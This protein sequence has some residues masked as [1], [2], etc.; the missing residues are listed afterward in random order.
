MRNIHK[1]FHHRHVLKK[2]RKFKSLPN[3]IL[4]IVLLIFVTPVLAD[5]LGPDRTTT[6]SYVET[7][8]IGVWTKDYDGSCNSKYHQGCIVCTWKRKPGSPC[9]DAKYWYKTGE[10]SKVVKET[11]EHPPAT[12]N[13]SLE[14]CTLQ[15]GWCVTA[16]ELALNADEPMDGYNILAIEGTLNGQTF[17][18][19]QASCSVPLSE[20]DNDLAYWALS[21][22]GDSS[23]MGNAT[24]KVD[25]VSPDVGLDVSG[26][27]GENG[28]YT[29]PVTVTS[30]GSDSTSGLAGTSLSVDSGAWQ[31]TTTLN[32]GIYHIAV[33][34]SDNAGN[35]SDA[36]TIISVD[37]TTPSIDLSVNGTTGNDGWYVSRMEVTAAADNST[38]GVALLEYSMDGGTYQSY[39]SPFS[40]S[41]GSHV[42]QFKATDAAGNFTETP[43]QAYHINSTAPAIS[44]PDS[45]TVDDVATYKA[46]DDGSGLASIRVIIEDED[47]HYAKITNKAVS[48]TKFR[49]EI[50]WDGK[51]ND[52][53]VA[54]PGTYLVWVKA[55]D[56]AGN[57]ATR[58]GKVVVNDSSL[59]LNVSQQPD[60]ASTEMVEMPSP[61]ADLF[62]EGEASPTVTNNAASPALTYGGS[63]S[64]STGTTD[65][66]S[67]LLAT[68]TSSTSSNS[69]STVL[70]GAA[71]AAVVGAATSYALDEKRK[72]E[73][74][75]EK[76]AR[77]AA[78][79]AAQ[80]NAAEEARK[81]ESWLEGYAILNAQ[82]EEARKQ[83]ATDAQISIFKQI[84]E[85]KGLGTA[86][87]AAMNLTEFLHATATQQTRQDRA[88][89]SKL[90]RLEAE[91]DAEW[92][93]SH[94]AAIERVEEEKKKELQDG[95]AA[96][97]N[98]AQAGNTEASNA[99]SNWWEN[100]KSSVAE[101]IIQ[102]F[103]TYIY[104]P[105]LEPAIEKT[106][107]AV[108]KGASWV[109][110]HF[111]QPVVVPVVD[112]EKQLASKEI[113]WADQNIYQPVIKPIVDN[114]VNDIKKDIDYLNEKV[115]QPY[116]ENFYEPVVKPAMDKLADKITEGIE[117]A[118]EKIY[119]PVIQ[120]AVEAI[121]TWT[122]EQIYQ[123][124]IQPV[125]TTIDEKIYQPFIEPVVSDIDK[126][127]YQPYLKPLNDA[128][129]AWW[130]DYGEW[131]HNAIDLV[132][133]IPGIGDIADG[134][135]SLI[136]LA[137]GRYL[138]ATISA[139]S[140]IP[141]V[142]D[143]G[144]A[145]KVGLEVSEEIVEEG[146]EVLI[147]K[148]V[149][150]GGEEL[151]EKF[152]KETVEQ[153]AETT[154]KEAGEELSEKIVKESVEEITE[155][156]V[157]ETGEEL[158]S[159][160]TQQVTKEIAETTS[161]EVSEVVVGATQ[162]ALNYL[163]NVPGFGELSKVGDALINLGKREF[164]DASISLVSIVPIVGEGAANV[165][166]I[167]K[168][169][170]ELWGDAA[171]E[172]LETLTSK[173]AKE[174]AEEM[175]ELAVKEA[176]EEL[177][178]KLVQE[179]MEEVVEKAAQESGEELIEK[180]A[181]E[182]VEEA[183][184]KTIQEG[185]E[186]LAEKAVQETAEETA[187]KTAKE[188]GEELADKTTQEA[189]EEVSEKT[190]RE[191]G[192]EI[193]EKTTDE[194]AEAATK[195]SI[196]EAGEEATEALA[197]KTTKEAADEAAA[198]AAKEAFHFH[199][200]WRFKGSFR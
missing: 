36:S 129:S 17:A 77:Q 64:K 156:T 175:T 118:N 80:L 21:S 143:L 84:G 18:C 27:S 131:V 79:Q 182:T 188:A 103:K 173:F 47:E 23:T 134:I 194:V 139:L 53:T 160:A 152:T 191:S 16:P 142:G 110:E 128:A 123:P 96:Y 132:G 154:V 179:S 12:I 46:Q 147:E 127:I 120:P 176:G 99:Q 140:M 187:E 155:K 196:K 93:A 15:N 56:A 106:K 161:K 125:L 171:K 68:G 91:E 57:S 116:L 72:R 60:A 24:A 133:L 158:A 44:L 73:E 62:E 145:G 97:Y 13:G 28:W 157:K 22:W 4:V 3:L 192:E 67:L 49:G 119:E 124:L 32:E 11:V 117:W 135:N 193:I 108:T 74:E 200:Q 138:E 54:P 51:F 5:Y 122:N 2:F 41:D 10:E 107:E 178:T 95:L 100:G 7:Y 136:Y 94:A 66:A 113:E 43:M 121:S 9:G 40:I 190:A 55:S 180:A 141:L 109:D 92:A 87:G 20:G 185:S 6:K 59:L 34:A 114:A 78:K 52:G 150:E 162:Q 102:P 30:T 86:V 42:F 168:G 167:L 39:T 159:Q 174:S 144:K 184:E 89:E 35:V 166:E 82:I 63:T 151:V 81:A 169:T 58:L 198:K 48:G 146:A 111:V 112:F 38:S 153:V 61:P 177:G 199:Q 88:E 33:S 115:Y 8:D 130:D 149:K 1:F 101:N 45:W 14:N 164:F 25:T 37:M 163:G 98:A 83:G 69:A 26:S 50:D 165:L 90:Q 126:Y 197:E 195:K 29:S 104:Q 172:A 19:E 137:E 181:V 189:F 75:E 65:Q 71:A 70:W 148:A 186:E 170:K 183:A 76:Q 105:V 31:S 85:T